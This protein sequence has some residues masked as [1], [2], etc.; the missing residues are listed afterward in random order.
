MMRSKSTDERKE[1]EGFVHESE[2]AQFLG[3]L[4]EASFVGACN[5]MVVMRSAGWGAHVFKERLLDIY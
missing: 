2:R 4:R 1:N 3:S 5:N